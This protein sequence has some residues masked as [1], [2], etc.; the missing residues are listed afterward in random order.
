MPSIPPN[1]RSLPRDQASLIGSGSA[2]SWYVYLVDGQPVTEAPVLA[3]LMFPA[4]ANSVLTTRF[5]PCLE[6]AILGVALGAMLYRRRPNW[7]TA[8][9]GFIPHR[10]S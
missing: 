5:F 1:L 3:G 4:E 10:G 8:L 2:S 9:N 6:L 7:R